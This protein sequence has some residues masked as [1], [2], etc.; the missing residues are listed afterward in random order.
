M[1]LISDKQISGKLDS[2]GINHGRV[3]YRYLMTA[4]R[5]LLDQEADREKAVELYKKVAEKYEGVSWNQVERG[6][7]LAIKKT[8]TKL[9]NKEFISRIYD[10]LIL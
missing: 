4:L 2:K 6:I 8:N 5:L 9:T 7:R 10:E 3:G 1:S